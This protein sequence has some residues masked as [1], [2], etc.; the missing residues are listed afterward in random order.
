MRFF[1]YPIL[2]IVCILLYGC[3]C[4]PGPVPGDSLALV[5]YPQQVEITG[6]YFNPENGGLT[7]RVSGIGRRAE[8]VIFE[9]LAELSLDLYYNPA[10][11][12]VDPD[13]WFGIPGAD[14][15]FDLYCQKAKFEIPD[16]LDDE[17]YVLMISRNG[18]ILAAKSTTGI[19][20]GLRTLQ[21]LFRQFPDKPGLPCMKIIDWPA[22]EE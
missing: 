15:S 10:D 9:Q 5:P 11:P 12:Q 8:P 6:G 7:G 14:P 20:S 4:N 18:S 1:F 2:P 22:L 19:S 17:G 13:F 16:T 21:Q 3:S